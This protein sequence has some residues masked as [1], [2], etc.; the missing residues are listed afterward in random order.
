MALI[1]MTLSCA[2]IVVQLFHVKKVPEALPAMSITMLVVLAL[3]YMTPLVLNFEAL[4]KHSNKQT[5]PF[6]GGG[7]L[8][9]QQ[10]ATTLGNLFEEEEEVG[11]GGGASGD[12]RWRDDHRMRGETDGNRFPA[13]GGGSGE[14]RAWRR[15]TCRRRG[16]GAGEQMA[17]EAELAAG[18]ARGGEA[19]KAAGSWKKMVAA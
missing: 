11:R 2:F 1:S 17:C 13:V 8:D 6:S 16:R 14:A 9:E 19:E 5:V 3:G 18:E 7:W 10:R 12:K 15:R 4:F